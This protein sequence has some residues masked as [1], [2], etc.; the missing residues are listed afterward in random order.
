MQRHGRIVFLGRA[1]GEGGDLY[2]EAYDD[3][4]PHQLALTDTERGVLDFAKKNCAG[5]VVVLNSCNTMQVGELEETR[6]L[7]QLSRCAP[8]VQSALRAWQNSERHCE[9]LRQ[10][11]RYLCCR[12]HADAT[13]VNFNKGDGATS[14]S[15]AS[16]TRDIWLSK[17]KGG[18]DF[19][20]RF[21][22]Y[23][24]GVYMATVGTRPPQIWTTSLLIICLTV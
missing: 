15:N 11:G 2:A 19:D 5:V 24:E 20:A 3:G 1:G 23:E 21:R 12:L 16:Y 9:P 13:Y 14:Y 10:N 22:E 4:T 18:P 7:M 6:I 17:F 8:P